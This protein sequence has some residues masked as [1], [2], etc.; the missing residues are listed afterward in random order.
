MTVRALSSGTI[1]PGAHIV[2]Q[3]SDVGQFAAIRA[4]G[5]GGTTGSWRHRHLCADRCQQVFFPDSFHHTGLLYR[6][7]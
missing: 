1:V 2:N 5:T 3:D 7:R 4:L 6:E